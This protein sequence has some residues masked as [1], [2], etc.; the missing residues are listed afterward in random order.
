[1]RAPELKARDGK[2]SFMM[3]QAVGDLGAVVRRSTPLGAVARLAQPSLCSFWW[4]TVNN[5][6]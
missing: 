2:P 3:A 5:Y 6:R 4:V 1:V